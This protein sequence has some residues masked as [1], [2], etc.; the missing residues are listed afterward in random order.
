MLS[1]SLLCCSGDRIFFSFALASL[2]DVA[3]WRRWSPGAAQL[4]LEEL[5][6][7]TGFV[8]EIRSRALAASTPIPRDL[9]VAL[10]HQKCYRKRSLPQQKCYPAEQ[11]GLVASCSK[12]FARVLGS[13]QA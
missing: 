5:R 13:D 2:L 4:A 12:L 11:G 3:S 1:R 8:D 10:P 7:I 9:L 6:S